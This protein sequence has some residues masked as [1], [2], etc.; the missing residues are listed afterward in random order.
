[1]DR[2]VRDAHAR[3]RF[4]V[5]GAAALLAAV[6]AI[7]SCG[8]GGGNDA[9]DKSD[10]AAA[11]PG[12][13]AALLDG[14]LADAGA[15]TDADAAP[16]GG[17]CGPLG[18]TPSIAPGT[19]STWLAQ[20]DRDAAGLR[21]GP[22]SLVAQYVDEHARR[23]AVFAGVTTADTTGT[24]GGTLRFALLVDGG[25]VPDP[26]ELADSDAGDAGDAAVAAPILRSGADGDLTPGIPPDAGDGG[27]YAGY[28]RDYAGGGTVFVCP[29][30]TPIEYFFHG[31]NHT[32]PFTGERHRNAVQ[33]WTGLGQARWDGALLRLR[34]EQQAIGLHIS[35]TW[36]DPTDAGTLQQPPASGS[37]NVVFDPDDGYLY[38]F[39]NDRTDDAEYAGP[40]F[41]CATMSCAAVARATVADVCGATK[42]PWK[43]LYHGDFT[44]PGV[45][46]DASTTAQYPPG[47]GGRFTPLFQGIA[48]TPQ[49]TR[50]AGTWIVLS[51]GPSDTIVVRTA[52][53]LTSWSS[54]VTVAQEMPGYDL[55]YPN[56]VTDFFGAS[57][58]GP[59]VVTYTRRSQTKQWRD[60]S[61]LMTTL[62]VAWR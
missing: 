17:A 25:L 61:V 5:V 47:T 54:P 60:A 7:A 56:L 10:A 43:K 62:D 16:N 6:A 55:L 46:E 57:R 22:D 50:I 39:Y 27:T 24:G 3:R 18:A 14:A 23:F 33:G 21:V 11:A 58:C 51:R 19:T 4:V 49:A 40:P 48:P 28:D 15:G 20:A 34:K 44:E 36:T 35:N 8:H 59:W 31:E 32:D 2:K 53:S 30:G 26:T 52:R 12:P 1:M 41:N 42:N 45:L 37:G 9:G 38:L 13:D 29:G